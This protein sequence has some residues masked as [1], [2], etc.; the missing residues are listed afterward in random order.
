MKQYATLTLRED[1]YVLLDEKGKIILSG[2]IPKTYYM[3]QKSIVFN[4]LSKQGWDIAFPMEND[5][6]MMGNKECD[7]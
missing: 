2:N 3:Y 7:T 4:I 5:W 1:E 6:Y